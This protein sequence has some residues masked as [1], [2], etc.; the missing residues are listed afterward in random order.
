VR[1]TPGVAN[2]WQAGAGLA[3][4][5]SPQASAYAYYTADLASRGNSHAANLG[6][7]WS[8]AAPAAAMA[9]SAHRMDTLPSAPLAPAAAAT[10]A[11][12]AVPASAQPA[13][14]PSSRG[15]K[16]APAVAGAA[17][18]AAGAGA[19]LADGPK[20]DAGKMAAD[21]QP[22]GKCKPRHAAGA[23]KAAIAKSKRVGPRHVP[24]PGK[25]TKPAVVAK[26]KRVVPVKPKPAAAE[27]LCD[28]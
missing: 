26:K 10:P 15:D 21:D 3:F 9:A 12:A 20:A 24:A 7:R 23:K 22:L 17:I 16:A 25:G 19:A 1:G 27:P 6:V 4:D 13:D 11:A 5:I 18:A 14:D 28:G 8:F 2:H